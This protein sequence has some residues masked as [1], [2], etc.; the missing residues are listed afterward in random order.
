MDKTELFKKLESFLEERVPC[1]P[2]GDYMAQANDEHMKAMYEIFY[3][4]VSLKFESDC[5]GD[6]PIHVNI[7][8]YSKETPLSNLYMS[9]PHFFGS[10]G[11][12]RR[13]M[14]KDAIK[15]LAHNTSTSSDKL[16]RY[17]Q[18]LDNMDAR[19]E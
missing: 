11:D 15:A 9:V 1:G 19:G 13:I 10:H 12:E 7:T 14:L 8:D 2:G 3:D 17:L 16:G 6:L 18:L 5:D 4:I